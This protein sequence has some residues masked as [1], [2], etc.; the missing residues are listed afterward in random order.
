MRIALGI[1]YD[2]HEFYG[3]QAQK[4]L[5]TVQ[6]HLESAL[7]KV[8]D[9]PITV[10]CA[11]RTDAGV[12]ATGQVIHFDTTKDRNMRAWVL[13]VNTHL[14]PTIAVRWAEQVDDQFH[15]R[16]S[17]LSRRYCYFIYNN[18]ARSAI[19]ARRAA[20]HYE[21]LNET[22]MQQ[23]G[24][25]LIG[26][27]D[28]SSFRS[29]QCESKTPIRHITSLT[30]KRYHDLMIIEVEAN[31]FLHHMVRNIVGVLMEIGEGR[32]ESDWMQEVLMAKD[33]KKA[34]ETAS[35]AGLYLVKVNYPEQYSFPEVSELIKP[36]LIIP[37]SPYNLSN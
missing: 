16:F 35:P 5:P 13:G 7:S 2:G 18:T 9:E 14:P 31:A 22:A 3:W 20:W 11:G 37:N 21:K 25:Y 30:V 6:G 27:H 12:H 36:L 4:N 15:A 26:E 33:R 29:S 1:E 23:A 32:R 17:A 34:A 24:Q 28:F 8:A 10:F 19:W